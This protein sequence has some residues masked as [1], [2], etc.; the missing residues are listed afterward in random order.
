MINFRRRETIW[1]D[2]MI[3]PNCKRD[4]KIETTMGFLKYLNRYGKQIPVP[5]FGERCLECGHLVHTANQEANHMRE[6]DRMIM[7]D[8]GEPKK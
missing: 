1:E 3:C 4:A 8:S 7:E 5:R 2:V 6:R